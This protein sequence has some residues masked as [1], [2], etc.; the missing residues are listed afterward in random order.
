MLRNDVMPEETLP[1]IYPVVDSFTYTLRQVY[2]KKRGL[3]S[4][5]E[6][7]GSQY[8]C[9]DYCQLDE[10]YGKLEDIIEESYS[11]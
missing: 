2:N 11:Y 6:H 7:E 9:E 1:F 4:K 5:N 10:N 3:F 8:S